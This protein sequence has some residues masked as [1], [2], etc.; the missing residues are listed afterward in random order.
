[1]GSPE[2]KLAASSRLNTSSRV[3]GTGE[4]EV[5]MLTNCRGGGGRVEMARQQ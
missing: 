2:I 5:V 3:R 1:L 4:E